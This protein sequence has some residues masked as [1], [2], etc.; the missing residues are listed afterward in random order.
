LPEVKSSRQGLPKQVALPDSY[1][2]FFSFPLRKTG[3]SGVVT[4]TR[5][6]NVMPSK[7]E[8]GLTGLIQPRP[9]F[10]EEERISR[11][12]SYPSDVADPEV[13]YKDLDS[14]GRA[15]VVDLGLFV[16][17][18]VYCPNDGTGS[19]ER[20]DFKM[21]YHRLL[22]A[23][24]DG[25]IQEGRQVMV[26]GDLNAC[27]AVEDH[28]EG[29]LMV[30]RGLAEGLQGEEGFWG[31]E[32]R[33][34]IRD[35]LIKDDGTGCLVD[36]ARKFWPGRKGMYTCVYILSFAFSLLDRFIGWNTKISARETN[37]GT[38]IDFILITPGLIPWIQSADIQPH[39]KGS[40]HCPVFVDL[41]D[42]II[43]SDGSSTSL[44]DVLGVPPRDCLA[45]PPRLAAKYW[46]EHKQRPLSTFFVKKSDVARPSS[47]TPSSS[48][49][50]LGAQ[51]S[52]DSL[53]VECDLDDI[54]QISQIGEG[55]VISTTK[56]KIILN[57]PSSSAK[58]AKR[59]SSQAP[60]QGLSKS[61]GKT[62]GSS[63]QSTIASF[64]AQTQPLAASTSKSR[65]RFT[66]NGPSSSPS[67]SRKKSPQS[68]IDSH[69]LPMEDADED[70]ECSAFSSQSEF[71]LS[72]PP[73]WPGKNTP[74]EIKQAWR[75]FLAPTQIPKCTV[76]GEPAKEY[77][78]NKPG[79]NKGKKFFICSR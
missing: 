14:E 1:N 18:N 48:Q 17:I 63:S 26:V 71:T 79:P 70:A 77:T 68:T 9:P 55:A 31:K 78:V 38:R 23:R 7:A 39:V 13:D 30:A 40:D 35:W 12:G 47:R 58:R 24:V 50:M 59:S 43:N 3:Y 67:S 8:E 4:Y 41:R 69:P 49:Q 72:S 28:C 60:A 36:I 33:R 66:S 5:A 64:F 44:R 21:Q 74:D 20:E 52:S 11:T 56:R 46:D 51:A 57:S 45:Q 65:S 29:P 53:G 37:Y 61:K 54:R 6:D 62:A 2:S 25:L 10:S 32:Y 16:L 76:H 42:E 34:W 73:T 15:V 75:S 22:E 19:K 27:A